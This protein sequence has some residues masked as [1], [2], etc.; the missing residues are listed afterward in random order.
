MRGGIGIKKLPNAFSFKKTYSP[1]ISVMVSKTASR[2]KAGKGKANIG[3]NVTIHSKELAHKF[4]IAYNSSMDRV[5]YCEDAIT[6]LQNYQDQGKTS[7][8]GSL[9]DFSEFQSFT[10]KEWKE[11][12]ERTSELILSRTSPD[13]VTI[14]FQS[15]IKVDGTWV[16]KAFLV[17]K[18]AERLGHELLWHKI[19]CRA[20]VGTVMFGRPS[21]SHMLCFSQAVR[22][23]LSKS[24]AD[25]IADLG[26]KTWVRGMGLEASL[27]ASQFI[28][29]HTSSTTLIN[30]FCGEGSALAAANYLGLNAIGI[31]RSPKRAQK[32]RDLR[33]APD[34][35]SWYPT[36]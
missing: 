33:I 1:T 25:V 32:A 10:L 14:F 21:Y 3:G 27:M 17:Q 35:K 9:P 31:E 19:F 34:G 23:D 6:W 20:P 22:A 8:L 11:W 12:F 16:D 18:S 36:E 4:R 28:K 26:S 7:F 5:V 24:T 13:G 2:L 30:P 15:D 29:K